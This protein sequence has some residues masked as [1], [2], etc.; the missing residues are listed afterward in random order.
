MVT[1]HNKPFHTI[2]ARLQRMML[3]LQRFD[4][5]LTYKKGKHLYLATT[6]S[7]AP[8]CKASPHRAEQPEFEVMTVQL[9]SPWRLEELG[10]YTAGD[11]VLQKLTCFIQRG[12]PRRPCSVTTEVR[13]F[14]SFRDELTVEDRI[15]MKGNRAVY[16]LPC[17]RN[18]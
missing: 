10:Q 16:P 18:T 6:L 3:Q 9:I 13:P 11:R 8:R 15:I 14:F 5:T 2:P 7:R 12:W 4:L 17:T 1:I